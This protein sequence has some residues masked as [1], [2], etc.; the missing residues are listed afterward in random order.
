MRA[1]AIR[2][3]SVKVKHIFNTSIASGSC[4]WSCNDYMGRTTFKLAFPAYRNHWN[5]RKARRTV[6][7]NAI[8]SRMKVRRATR[9]VGRSPQWSQKPRRD[10]F[11]PR[12]E[13]QPT[14]FEFNQFFVR[15]TT[16][17]VQTRLHKPRPTL[18]PGR[19]VYSISK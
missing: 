16:K 3:R 9:C 2:I 14:N 6:G 4:D 8:E 12:M 10:F 17:P 13:V 19:H 11:F 7:D 5:W 15:S 18:P 1:C